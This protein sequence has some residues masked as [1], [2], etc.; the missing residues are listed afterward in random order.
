MN[1]KH[2]RISQKLIDKHRRISQKL[3]ETARCL[4]REQG[5]TPAAWIATLTQETV[6]VMLETRFPGVTRDDCIVLAHR[7]I[8]VMFEAS[9]PSPGERH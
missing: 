6:M 1:L 3:I 8:D 7:N 2:R 5:V 9:E 4:A